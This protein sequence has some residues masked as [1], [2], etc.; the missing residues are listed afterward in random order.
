MSHC[1]CGLR[2][3]YRECALTWAK[4]APEPWKVIVAIIGLG[5]PTDFQN[6]LGR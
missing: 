1:V 6:T 4:G 3:L 2:R 5:H